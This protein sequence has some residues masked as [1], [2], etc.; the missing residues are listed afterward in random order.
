MELGHARGKSSENPDFFQKAGSKKK[1]DILLREDER[2][3]R[4]SPV[5]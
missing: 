1:R 4:K 3:G 2:P 5:N